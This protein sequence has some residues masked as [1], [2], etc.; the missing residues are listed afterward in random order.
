M[1]KDDCVRSFLCIVSFTLKNC[2]VLPLFKIR[3]FPRICNCAS[4]LSFRGSLS[5]ALSMN[6]LFR[7][8]LSWSSLTYMFVPFSYLVCDRIILLS[9]SRMSF[10]NIGLTFPSSGFP[11]RKQ[12]SKSGFTEVPS[13]LYSP[14]TYFSGAIHV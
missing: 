13:F 8:F 9:F 6:S 2:D 4:G 14:V 1:S 11:D 10:R 7:S 3:D 12:S 5:V